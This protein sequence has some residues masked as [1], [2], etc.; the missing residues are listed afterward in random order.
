MKK[1]EMPTCGGCR[2]C[3]MACSF[4][5]EEAFAPAISSIKIMEKE[6]D[7]GFFVLLS[8]RTEGKIQPCDGCKDFPVPLCVQYCREEKDLQKILK[9]FTGRI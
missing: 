7:A 1:F 4:R 9:E 2:T 5:H 3:E 8:E 6:N